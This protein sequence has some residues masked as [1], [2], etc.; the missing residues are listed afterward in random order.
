LERG[1]LFR[2]R[3]IWP[4]P[5]DAGPYALPYSRFDDFQ[6]TRRRAKSADFNLN[7]VMRARSTL[8]GAVKGSV[9]PGADP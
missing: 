4:E 1:R 7:E 8:I 3:L 5:D 9:T 2:E 6:A